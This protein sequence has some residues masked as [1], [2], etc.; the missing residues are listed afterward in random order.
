MYGKQILS[1]KSISNPEIWQNDEYLSLGF[2]DE[3]A[4]KCSA[5]LKMER[6]SS[7]FVTDVVIHGFCANAM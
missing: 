4:S 7:A 2:K 3:Y 1:I 5:L 6:L